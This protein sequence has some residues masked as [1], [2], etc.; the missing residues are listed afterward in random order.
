MLLSNPQAT[1][2]CCHLSLGALDGSVPLILI[3]ERGGLQLSALLSLVDT[4]QCILDPDVLE[5]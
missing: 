3:Q 5:S 4:E 1:L 2:S